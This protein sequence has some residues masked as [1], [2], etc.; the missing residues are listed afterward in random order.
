[1]VTGLDR[2]REDPFFAR[3]KARMAALLP[4]GEVV[5]VVD[6]GCGSGEDVAAAQRRGRLAVGI[7]RSVYMTREARRRHPKL[8]FVAAD[9]R[10]LPLADG[11]V[12]AVR[13]DRVLQHLAGGEAALSEWRRVL[14]GGGV[15]IS[16]DPDLTTAKAGGIDEAVATGVLA[17]RA[18]TRPGTDIVHT[19]DRALIAAGFADVHIER[20]VLDLASLDRADGM[21]GIAEWG[22]R[23][24]EANVVSPLVAR[25]WSDAVQRASRDGSLRFRCAYVL[26]IAR[27]RL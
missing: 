21:M 20:H 2:L 8:A 12:D 9:G 25:R 24:A 16:F 1:M 17:W 23:A 13:A 6:M 26:A 3:G 4:W 14:R 15:V 10:H 18:G 11:S 7:D 5:R 22:A 19:L 27:A